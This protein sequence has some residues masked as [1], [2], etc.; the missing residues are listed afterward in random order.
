M[1]INL[2]DNTIRDIEAFLAN[3]GENLDIATFIDQSVRQSMLSGIVGKIHKRNE[4]ANPEDLDA[5]I[6]EVVKAVRED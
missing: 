3:S 6:D 1:Q 5:L 4:S 2:P